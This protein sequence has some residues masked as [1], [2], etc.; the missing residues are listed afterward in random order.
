MSY[1]QILVSEKNIIGKIPSITINNERQRTFLF[2]QLAQ[3][4]G[5]KIQYFYIRIVCSQAQA[6]TALLPIYVMMTNT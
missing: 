5:I 4:T 1:K 6:N 2:V 3:K